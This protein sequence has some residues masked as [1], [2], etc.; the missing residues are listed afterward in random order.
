MQTSAHNKLNNAQLNL[1]KSFQYLRNE[2]EIEEIDSLVNFYLEK[3]LDD[4]IEQVEL[5]NNYSADVY[6]QWLNSKNR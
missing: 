6:E 1:I 5:Q 4:A 3:K 2:K